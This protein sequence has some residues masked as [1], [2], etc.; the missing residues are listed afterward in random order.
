MSIRISWKSGLALAAALVLT[1]CGGGG[2]SSGDAPDTASAADAPLADAPVRTIQQTAV[3][4]GRV[5]VLDARLSKVTGAVDVWVTLDDAP[6]AAAAAQLA[7]AAST[8][9]RTLSVKTLREAPQATREALAAHR[10]TV[11]SHQDALQSRLTTLGAQE[12]GRVHMA[13]NAIAV[14]V[15]ASKLKAI[16]ALPGVAKVRRVNHYEMSLSETVPYIGATAAQQAGADGTGVRVAV[17]DS[18]ID[19]THRHP[20][21]ERVPDRQ[22]RRRLRLRR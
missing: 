17:I 6:V 14:R 5:D 16:A 9:E 11:L 10:K 18:G 7:I 2:G 22:G 19:Y 12:L 1:A 13:H 4:G 8:T 20:R 3:P 21:P 15:D